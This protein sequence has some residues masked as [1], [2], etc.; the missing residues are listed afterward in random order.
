LDAHRPQPSAAGLG[1]ERLGGYGALREL[2]NSHPIH[3][4]V[5][6]LPSAEADW[7]LDTID[8][9]D[10]LGVTLRVVPE[11]LLFHTSKALRASRFEDDLPLPGVLL[12]PKHHQPEALF[13]KRSLDVLG[14]TLLLLLA[15][16]VMG[17]VALV[18]KLSEPR[19]PIIYCLRVV[20]QNGVPFRICKFRTM[21]PAA[22]KLKNEL[23]SRNEMKGPVFKMKND[24][25]ITPVGRF[26]RK[27]S[28][29][30]LPQLW[31]VVC[32]DLSLVGPRAPMPN[33][34]NRYEFW[35]KRRLSVK[36][37]LTCFWQIRGRNKVSSFDDWVNMDLEYIDNWSLWLDLKIL[38]LT[39]PAVLKGSGQ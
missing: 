15:A 12:L 8:A 19:V 38:F 34:L 1:L 10:E 35:Q 6:V 33:E 3:K 17:L 31:N 28:L 32:G 18:I 21:V 4:V 16:P 24:P 36:P 5:M 27:F 37:G 29:D 7:A 13:L 22:D 9:C 25:R 30:E 23:A 2:L 11:S 39:I 26:L 20:G 14:G